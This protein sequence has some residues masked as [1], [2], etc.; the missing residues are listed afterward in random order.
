MGEQDSHWC[1]FISGGSV[2]Y[3]SGNMLEL[4]NDAQ[5]LR[6]TLFPAVPR[7]LN[8]ICGEIQVPTPKIFEVFR[9]VVF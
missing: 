1:M 6:P 9:I 5:D 2:G 3:Y 4:L 7:I 8:K